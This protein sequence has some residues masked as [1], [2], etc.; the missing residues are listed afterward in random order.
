[1]LTDLN[2]K[3][4]Y[5]ETPYDVHDT[6]AIYSISEQGLKDYTSQNHF[7]H[8]YLNKFPKEIMEQLNQETNGYKYDIALQRN[9]EIKKE[10]ENN[11]SNSNE[12]KQVQK[13]VE[14]KKE[15][16]NEKVFNNKKPVIVGK[17]GKKV[18]NSNSNSNNNNVLD[19][20]VFH[21]NKEKYEV[22]IVVNNT[23]YIWN[24]VDVRHKSGEAKY[25]LMLE[26][27]PKVLNRRRHPRLPM[28]NPCQIVLKSKNRSFNGKMINISAGGFAFASS[29][30]EFAG[31]EGAKVEVKIHNADAVLSRTL[32]GTVMRCGMNKGEYIVGCKMPEKSS[33]IEQYVEMRMR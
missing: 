11:K 22:Q 30:S 28:D 6:F 29:V 32:Q 10:C 3:V 19:N 18:G 5:N 16:H 26:D 8:H 2:Q 31:C 25:H 20:D 17:K 7:S 24:G 4:H 21:K 1:M 13:K 27:A 14:F 15:V 9:E 33:E 23:V 12:N